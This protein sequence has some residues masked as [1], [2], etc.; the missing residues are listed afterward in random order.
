MHLNL[1]VLALR[2]A[3]SRGWVFSLT[4]SI[5]YPVFSSVPTIPLR[6]ILEFVTLECHSIS[7]NAAG[8]KGE[9]VPT[10]CTCYLLSILVSNLQY[11]G[12][13]V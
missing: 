4:L 3:S 11:L 5:T 12:L 2:F 10:H 6:D 9:S 8:T 7:L 13:I 1:T